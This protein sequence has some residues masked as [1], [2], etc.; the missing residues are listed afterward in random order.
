[1]LS[2][3]EFRG[4]RPEYDKNL[5]YTVKKNRW[6]KKVI[7]VTYWI[8]VLRN[9]VVNIIVIYFLLYVNIYLNLI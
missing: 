2:R 5:W 3:M 1:M 8:I 6:D 9:E 7:S 4:F